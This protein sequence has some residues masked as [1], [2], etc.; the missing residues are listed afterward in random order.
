MAAARAPED[1]KSELLRA[2]RDLLLESGLAGLSMRKVAGACDVSATAIYRHYA[3]KDALVAAAVVDG[4][5]TFASYLLDALEQPTPLRRFRTL[6]R[7][8]FDFSRENPQDYRL[9]FMTDCVELGFRRLDEVAAREISGTFQLLQDRIAEC[10]VA[11][12]FR[13]GEPRALAASTWSSLHGLASL[14]LTGQLGEGGTTARPL[15]ELHLE[16]VEAGLSR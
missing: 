14:L 8:Y 6:L 4:F 7:R 9:I 2:A 10:Q 15:I 12:H 1:T 16:L 11:G 13:A 3:D 5:R